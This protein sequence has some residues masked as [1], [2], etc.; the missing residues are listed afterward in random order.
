MALTPPAPGTQ[1][2]HAQ[3]A[4]GS[5]QQAGAF[6]PGWPP[7]LADP[8]AIRD[9]D[10]QAFCQVK[11]LV[12]HWDRPGWTPGRRA[13]YW[14]VTFDQH[15]TLTALAQHCQQRLA[16]LGLDPV[17][18]NG[19]HLTLAR[20]GFTDELAAEHAL[21]AAAAARQ[22]CAGL[23]AF[24]VSIGP[25]AG[26]RGAVRFTVTPWDR[27]V[28]LH[29]RLTQ[30]TTAALDGHAPDPGA[31]FRPHVSI[32][33]NPRPRPAGPVIDAVAALRHLP[34]AQALVTAA[35]LVC[36]RRQGRAYRWEVTATVPLDSGQAARRCQG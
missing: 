2:P 26:S 10:W 20:V 8:A 28:E 23:P 27:L 22:A 11:T 34:P 36:L 33:Y 13:W 30:A 17:P 32:A 16:H 25:L 21:A 1:P 9:Y 19:L 18:L 3:R 24:P 29:R 5:G 15:P 12:N 35:R 4:P 14:F 6:P 7:S 31:P